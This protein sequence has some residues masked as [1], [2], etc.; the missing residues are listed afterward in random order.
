MAG[1]KREERYRRKSQVPRAPFVSL[2]IL[3]HGWNLSHLEVVNALAQVLH[4][5]PD[6]VQL[7]EQR[8]VAAPA[9]LLRTAFARRGRTT[10]HCARSATN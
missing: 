7:G 6:V 10:R 4:L 2:F 1:R 9:L 3:N 5:L 8:L